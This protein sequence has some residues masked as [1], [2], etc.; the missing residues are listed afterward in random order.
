MT[1][2]IEIDVPLHKG[3][4]P[5]T[6]NLRLHRQEEARRAKKIRESVG[7][8][9]KAMLLG[10]HRH[11]TVQLHYLPGDNKRRDAPNLTATSKPAIDGLVDAGLVRDD[12]DDYVTEIM[13]IIHRGQG[14]PRRLW[15]AITIT[16][17]NQ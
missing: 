9:A 17:E 3:K 7:W 13:P 8:K 11:I 4:P 2:P 12:N 15:L 16:E 10:H 6:H 1:D 14:Q 5:L